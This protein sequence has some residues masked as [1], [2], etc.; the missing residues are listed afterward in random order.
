MHRALTSRGNCV[1][2]KR[3]QRAVVAAQ[4][5]ASIFDAQPLIA[6]ALV[7]G[8]AIVAVVYCALAQSHRPLWLDEACTY[9]T[10]QARPSELLRGVRMDGTPPLY[11]LLVYAVTRLA[12]TSEIAL[13]LTSM[14][15]GV[16]L[17]PAAYAVT[18][19]LAT[20]RAGVIAAGLT[21][22]SPLVHY[23]AVEA[24]NY[25]LVQL[26][27]VA[28]VYVTYRAMLAPTHLRWWV[29]LSLSQAIQLWTHNYALFLLP[30]P[31]I[32]CLFRADH[33]RAPTAIKAAAASACAFFLSL[34]CVFRTVQNAGTGVSDWIGVFW[35]ETPPAFAILRSLEV[36]GFGGK[37]PTGLLSYL[38][39]APAMRLLALP[40]MILIVTMALLGWRRK[41]A[42]L[43]VS[44]L[45]VPLIGAWVYS[46]VRSPLYVV[47]RYDTIVLPVFLMLL[48]VGLDHAFSLSLWFGSALAAVV[49]GLAVFSSSST[50][51]P[52]FVAEPEEVMAA[53]YL[54]SHAASTDEIVSTGHRQAIVAYYMDRAGHHMAIRPFPFEMSDHPGWFSPARML[55]DPDRL[56]HEG[57]QL[58]ATLE[59][60]AARGHGVWVLTTGPNPID[61]YLYAALQGHLVID[62]ARSQRDSEVY[63]FEP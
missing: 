58:A 42:M 31:A 22:I 23:Y 25:E 41:A 24:R 62:E 33:P 63:F 19:Q 6:F 59:A 49:L 17:V 46:L 18:T 54:N 8:F 57:A 56:T 50:L 61:Q 13:R 48:A 51:A 14:I 47:G 7:G 35:R 43:L 10:I 3:K 2:R 45:L 20:R 16:A 44:F 39:S 5:A 40:T 38:G 55:R 30:A 12:G 34:S 26:E 52:D 9:W 4:R 32:V 15:A 29:L 1:G 60:A 36:F 37:Y 11:F 21:V 53:Q 28:I 27:T